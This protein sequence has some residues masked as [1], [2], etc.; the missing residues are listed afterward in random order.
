MEVGMSFNS[1]VSILSLVIAS[2]ALAVTA[3]QAMR[4]ARLTLDDHQI[5]VIA[6]VF[7]EIRSEAFRKHYRRILTFPNN[8]RLP[9]GFE[10]LH[11]RRKESAYAVCYF[12]EHL[13]V[14][15]T[16]ALIP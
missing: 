10:S 15:A 14:L 9:N 3:W 12:F 1:W 8:E 5:Q 7:R 13:G 16:R 4:T 6:D 11:K 2:L